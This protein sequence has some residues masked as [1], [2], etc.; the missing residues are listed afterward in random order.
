[1]LG[2]LKILFSLY[3]YFDLYDKGVKK[4]FTMQLLCDEWRASTSTLTQ[5]KIG[6]MWHFRFRINIL[7][8]SR[9]NKIS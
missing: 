8:I 4:Y 7:S 9:Q 2:I 6:K 5:L 3:S 1:M